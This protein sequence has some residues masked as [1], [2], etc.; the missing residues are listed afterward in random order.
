MI[1]S[2]LLHQ[3][4]RRSFAFIAFILIQFVLMQPSA[5]QHRQKSIIPSDDRARRASRQQEQFRRQA[6]QVTTSSGEFLHI[7]RQHMGTSLLY[8]YDDFESGSG[9]WS[10]DPNVGGPPMPGVEQWH[11]TAA[12]ASSPTH[13]WWQGI[14]SLGNYQ[15][16]YPL[17]TALISPAIDLSAASGQTTLLFAENIMTEKGWDFCMVDV[18]TN[19]GA[20]W[21]HLRGGYGNSPTG[22]SYGW[23]VTTLDLTPY[24]GM[25]I[26]IRF[27]FDTGDSLYNDFPGWFV[28]DVAIFDQSGTVAGTVFYDLNNNAVQDVGELGL[29]AWQVKVS[30]P[31]TLRTPTNNA[32][33]FSLQ[34]PLGSYQVSE[35]VQAW[36]TQTAPPSLNWTADLTTSG[37]SISGLDFGNYRHGS[38]IRGTVFNDANQD[39]IMNPGE[40]PLEGYI[41]AFDSS[42]EWFDDTYSDSAGHYSFF[43]Y[44]PTQYIVYGV[45]TGSWFSTIPGGEFV[46]YIID[47]PRMDTVYSGYNFGWKSTPYSG[48]IRGSVF[49]DL[50]QD[51]IQGNHDLRAQGKMVSLDGP[52]H[53]DVLTD[54]SGIFEFDF[55]VAGDY[56]IRLAEQQGWRQT[57]PESTYAVTLTE[58]GTK[59]SLLF[60]VYELQHATVKG[61]A[62][63]DLNRNGTWDTLEP[64]LADWTVATFGTNLYPSET[65]TDSS[66]R[67]VL[68]DLVPGTRTI[69]LIRP[70][71]WVQSW[72]PTM[73][74]LI[75]F[76][77][78]EVWDGINFGAYALHPGSISGTLFNDQN[79]NA[80]RDPGEPPLTGWDI[81]LNGQST[82]TAVSDDSGHFRFD[83][84]WSGAYS[85]TVAWRSF[86]RQTYP[87][88]LQPHHVTLVDEEERGGV[89][90][91]MLLD[92][93]FSVAFRS[94]IP[95]SI[96]Y[97]RDAKGYFR[98]PVIMKY[99]RTSWQSRWIKPSEVG[100]DSAKSLIIQMNYT[101]EPG[102]ITSTKGTVTLL[103]SKI[104]Q[105]DFSA[106]YLQPNDSVRVGGYFAKKGV[107]AYS[108]YWWMTYQDL[109]KSFRQTSNVIEQ[110]V[111][112]MPTPNAI[113]V[114]Q[115]GAGANVIIGTGGAHSIL[116]VTYK[117]ILKTLYD[118][119]HGMA[120][121][122]PRC[123]DVWSS[124]SYRPI[125]KLTKTA[126]PSK[127]NNKLLGEALTLKTNIKASDLWLT[128]PGFGSLIFNEGTGNPFNEMSIRA[129]SLKTDTIMSDFDELGR[130]CTH[131]DP[132]YQQLY[133][134]IR[135]IDSAFCG[136]ID[137]ADP[138]TGLPL[139][140]VR[141]LSQV[142][143]LRLDSSFA[144][145]GV[146]PAWTS[147]PTSE[148]DR[149][150]LY[151]N[152]PNPFNP[153]TTIS[154]NLP[155]AAMVTLKIYNTLGQ[156]ITTLLNREEMQD[157]SQEADFDASTLPS[158]VY[159]YQL[160]VEGIPDED[161]ITGQT[162]TAIRKMLLVK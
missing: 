50:N 28:D 1:G 48:M 150:D 143:F 9:S 115:S 83:G 39:S 116:H 128:P 161:G 46:R 139:A 112:L 125:Y 13:S 44:T 151:Q 79:G 58:G 2:I 20:S 86:W 109:T 32:G 98:K 102:T 10:V 42:G 117:D 135:M 104:I 51:G 78:G 93:S 97:A 156:E 30:G 15:Y 111:M 162:F 59:D 94:F 54:S 106:S 36:W 138:S 108:K 84:L 119:K 22:N 145:M 134:T 89:D 76:G 121:G 12:S 136:P 61:Y 29:D 131:D 43:V 66:G 16:D 147:L 60:G 91:G 120:D 73:D 5:A 129:I 64:P 105:I 67:Y 77:E 137:V 55:L 72:L 126:P 96:A 70:P 152:Y 4:T 34:L 95:E 146:R 118:T 92:S 101:V 88:L 87:A 68:T 103:S 71:K 114:L 40:I 26:N 14:D 85:A 56:V 155:T 81:H 110:Y 113:N 6:S 157:G 74:W 38:I 144:G 99:Y 80:I 142:P 153:T 107:T 18:S 21:T 17:H 63:N 148:P 24:N 100:L 31:I 33:Q 19:S 141:P 90:F 23:R 57:F 69:H 132:Y 160:K 149:F 37:Q 8:F 41:F 45:I 158:G 123:L 27:F 3:Y 82:G 11:L 7:D 124:T 127:H 35:E 49:Q 47:V 140:P 159:F 154:F 52:F 75:D 25:Q 122:D 53:R 133:H 65:H 62:F 130:T